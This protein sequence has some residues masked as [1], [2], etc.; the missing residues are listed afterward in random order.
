MAFVTTGEGT[1]AFRFDGKRLRPAWSNGTAGTSPV[2][3]GGVLW[4]YDPGGG[5]VAYR[6]GTGRVIHRFAVPGGHWNSPIVAGGRV[7][8]P[9]GNAN[10]HATTGQLSVLGP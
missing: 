9:T 10:N 6:P 4:I 8:L 5:L 7:Y 3:A 1:A 2:V